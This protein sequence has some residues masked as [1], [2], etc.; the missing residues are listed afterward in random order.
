MAD[1]VYFETGYIVINGNKFEVQ[2]ITVNATRDANPYYV[3]GQKNPLTIRSGRKKIEFTFKRAFS[4]AVLSRMYE[5]D[6]E[7]IMVLWNADP[8]T[9]QPLMTL[10]GCKLSQDNVGPI[11][12][13]DVVMEDI[14]GQAISRSVDFGDIATAVSSRCSFSGNSKNFNM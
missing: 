13:Q 6:C 2:E 12:G 4:D 7:F 3:A 10:N 1:P 9:D 8:D 14:Q 11:N 5:Y